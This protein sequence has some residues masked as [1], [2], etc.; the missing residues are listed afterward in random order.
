M[1]MSGLV[2]VCPPRPSDFIPLAEWI[3][4]STLFNV[5]RTIQFFRRYIDVKLFRIWFKNVKY[6]TYLKQRS[7]LVKR[8]Y[9]ARPSFAQTL[10]DIH[11][12]C[13]E[14]KKA[15]L[16]IKTRIYEL[17]DFMKRSDEQRTVAFNEFESY[18]AGAGGNGDG[19]QVSM[20]KYI[21]RV[22]EDLS[23]RSR[24]PDENSIDD[25]DDD[26]AH[27]GS[28]KSK[29]MYQVRK[30][31]AARL[32]AVRKAEAELLMMDDFI[33]LA[34]YMTVETLVMHSIATLQSFLIQLQDM[35][36]AQARNKSLFEV[37]LQF[38]PEGRSY[39]IPDLSDIK[40]G[41]QTMTEGVVTI[42]QSVTRILYLPMLKSHFHGVKPQGPHTAKLITD[43]ETFLKTKHDIDTVLSKNYAHRG[44]QPR[45][46]ELSC[47][48]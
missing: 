21:D 38:G 11:S 4:K 16:V 13:F 35:Y 24:M 45:L 19:Q 28:E 2:H 1:S 47:D 29:S 25:L 39:F 34:D 36:E 26:S 6:R 30:E 7:R 9:L 43:D 22:A 5:L 15:Q 20:Q 23:N 10:I 46:R 17:V 32:A 8:F 12:K 31:K 40:D 41:L 14:M 48:L 33:R 42:V 44:V 37:N 27:H 3:R 18:V